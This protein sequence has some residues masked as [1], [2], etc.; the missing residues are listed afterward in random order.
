AS[1]GDPST[2]VGEVPEGDPSAEL[3]VV[4]LAGGYR[5]VRVGQTDALV[6]DVEDSTSRGAEIAI[7]R[8]EHIGRWREVLERR[9]PGSTIPASAVE[10]RLL[11][12][13]DNPLADG[14]GTVEVRLP[15]GATQADIKVAVGNPRGPRL[16]C[17][18]LA[19][20]E[21]YGV[22]SLLPGGGA[23]LEEGQDVWVLD[24]NRQP[25]LGLTVGV[26]RSQSTDILKLIVSTREF[27]AQALQQDELP[28]PT[29]ERDI[30][31]RGVSLEPAVE[32]AADDWMT[33]EVVVTTLRESTQVAVT[34]ANTSPQTLAPGVVLLP[35]PAL[36]ASIGLSTPRL[37]SRDVDEVGLPPLL[38]DGSE[39]LVLQGERGPG[40]SERLVVAD[41]VDRSAVTPGQPLRLMLS[42]ALGE[43]EHIAAFA[44]DGELWLPVGGSRRGD[45][46][47]RGTDGTTEIH[48]DRLPEPVGVKD[49]FGSLKVVLRKVILKPLGFGYDWPRLL[50]V[51]P[52]TDGTFSGR[53]PADGELRDVESALVV[54]HGIIGDTK[55]M[56]EHVHAGADPIA[57]RYDV[58]LSFDYENLD[59]G[60]DR[61]AQDLRDR[62]H[63][64]GLTPEGGQRLDILAH[65]MGGLV[66]RCFVE[67]EGGSSVVRRVVTAGTPH[68]G[69]PWPSVQQWAT[70][71]LAAILNG[72]GDLPWP[73]AFAS[74][75]VGMLIGSIERFDTALDQMDA[76]SELIKVLQ[77]A[78]DPACPY[79]AIAGNR[80]LAV[81]DPKRLNAIVQRL[82][83]G[84]DLLF[85]GEPNDFA[86]LVSSAQGVP[87]GRTPAVRLELVAC[88]HFSYFSTEEGLSAVTAAL[89]G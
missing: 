70:V 78:A 63:A 89:R 65:S 48:I 76:G 67:R 28:R 75:A 85:K 77:N 11:G 2:L 13:N 80:A 6:A 59:T 1:G 25:R 29:P 72:V 26:G 50:V 40:G 16:Y 12:M 46:R 81:K 44:F 51:E 4:A 43:G 32:I 55:G 21:D 73:G 69:S 45:G 53:K 88:D 42:T 34:P 86:V 8:L 22:T 58:V 20:T 9:N 38:V 7:A 23:W 15:H 66:T 56:V 19:M 10:L 54:I 64:A 62:L 74:K 47:T 82:D 3:T 36:Q 49:L 61:T 24:R 52:Q 14:T 27:D 5:I 33:K 60:I 84:V 68:H 71:T 18:L 41:V 31:A 37:T 83:S 87:S 79:V 39:A 17:A 30:A 35:H 57:S